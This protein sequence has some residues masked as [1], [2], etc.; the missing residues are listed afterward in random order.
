MCGGHAWYASMLQGRVRGVEMS[1]ELSLLLVRQLV[2]T[3]E[4]AVRA[5]QDPASA[6]VERVTCRVRGWV[7]VRD[8]GTYTHG[9]PCCPVV[10]VDLKEMGRGASRVV[11]MGADIDISLYERTVG[12]AFA[13]A[14][15]FHASSLTITDCPVTARDGHRG[16]E[17]DGCRWGGGSLAYSVPMGDGEVMGT[18]SL[19]VLQI[20][21]LWFSHLS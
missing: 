6:S 9:S 10:A 21:G 11:A 3:W 17:R 18:A 13:Y 12:M 2:Q 20:D 15:S 4:G 1:C 16:M 19:S 5:T 14:G 7:E 8:L